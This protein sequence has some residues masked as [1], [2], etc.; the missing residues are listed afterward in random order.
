MT[1]A[2]HFTQFGRYEIIR[3]LGRSI[4]D[5]YLA[6]DP[7]NN[8]RVVLKILEQCRDAY[9]QL[10]E[11]AERRGASIQQQ[12]HALD[13]RI[14]EIYEMGEQN[15]CF[16][17][18]MQ[19]ADGHSLAEVLR[20][21]TRLEPL[22]AARYAAEICSQLSSLHSFQADIDGQKRAVVHGDIKP[23]N[24]Q[25]GPRGEVWLLDFGIA[26]SISATRSLTQHNLGSPA[27]CSPV[28]ANGVL[29][30]MNREH[31]YAIE[32]KK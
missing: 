13:P 21:D 19:H 7:E 2:L 3:K 15:G 9:T 18:T 26:K 23:S 25:I 8:R 32:E 29:Y 31:L 24:V 5:V 14:L 30:L 10:I 17:V 20:R 27:Y 4:S 12:L 16:Y 6:L 28:F 22:Q 11:D 1:P